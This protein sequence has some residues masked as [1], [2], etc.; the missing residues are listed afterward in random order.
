MKP[1]NPLNNNNNGFRF[2]A[3]I[4]HFCRETYF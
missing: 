2:A 3:P 1:D 4:L